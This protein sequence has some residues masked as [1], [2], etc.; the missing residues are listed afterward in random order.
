MATRYTAVAPFH[1]PDGVVVPGETIELSDKE[2]VRGI[3]TGALVP[4]PSISVPAKATKP[5]AAPQQSSKE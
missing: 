5:K 4:T 3:E 1:H 2:A